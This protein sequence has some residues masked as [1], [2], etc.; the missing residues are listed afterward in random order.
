MTFSDLGLSN[1]L[2]FAL[3]S[4]KI[5][6]PT[7]IQSE[8]YKPIV[9]GQDLI[10]ISETG[11]G[12][13]LAYLLPIY[14]KISC[15]ESG[16]QVLIIVPTQELAMQI[17][18]Q[19]QVLSNA[20]GTNILSAV[21]IGDGNIQRQADAL[22][23][24]PQFVIGTCGR[25]LQMIKIKKLSVHTVKTLIL[26]EADKLLDKNNIDS[27]KAIR[28]SLMKYTQVLLFSASLDTKSIKA[29]DFLYH[30]P[31]TVKSAQKAEIPA[32]IKHMFIIVNRRERIETLRKIIQSLA[33][34]KAII[35][36]NKSYDLLEATEKLQYHHYNADCLYGENNKNDR[37]KMIEQFK[38]GKLQYL[39]STDIAAR[40][41]QIEKISAVI[42]VNLPENSK[43]YLHRAGRC[44]RNGQQGLC[45]SIITENEIDKIKSYQKEFNINI[46]QKKLYQGKLVGK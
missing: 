2:I 8:A 3:N 44:G 32:L 9:S 17:H 1:E 31:I 7:K 37:K 13:T 30:N 42:N 23:Q 33:P 11:S 36:I 22:R 38:S 35:F 4:Q 18:K 43:D 40:G 34:E 6:S 12:K 24:K 10:G 15:N 21:L 25:I 46:I 5:T 16:V 19:I 26:D 27:I 41:L 45:I 20:S 14:N 39:I 29:G 28:K